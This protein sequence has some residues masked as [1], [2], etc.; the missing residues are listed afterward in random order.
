M[1]VLIS[2]FIVFATVWRGFS[3]DLDKQKMKDYAGRINQIVYRLS[4]DPND[5]QAAKKLQKTYSEALAAYRKEIAR[6]QVIPDSFRWTKTYELMDG[7]NQLSEDIL[8][9]SSANRVICDPKFYDV[10]LNDAKRKAV[11]ELYDCGVKALTTDGIKNAREAYACFAKAVEL[12]PQFGDVGKKMTEARDKGT[13][14]ILIEQV[15]AYA[16]YKNL[17]AVRFQESLL[18][19][20]RSDFIRNQFVNFYSGSEIKQRK[21]D[22]DWTLSIA[23]ID[24]EMEK[25]KSADNL[26]FTYINGVAEVKIVSNQDNR[27]ILNTRI[28][29]QYIWKSYQTS[30]DSGL[31]TLFD[32]FSMSMTEPVAEKLS[33]FL[34]K[35]TY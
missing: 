27:L 23:F 26:S 34:N 3:A 8:Y 32:A 21:M 20:L 24:I 15:A 29:G 35:A 14:S 2:I 25:V 30:G 28:P 18:N 22:P 1:R 9:N 11:Q 17:Y 5:G 19:K 33:E 10:E 16:H 7:L 31:Q 12:N 4:C 13:V 6:L